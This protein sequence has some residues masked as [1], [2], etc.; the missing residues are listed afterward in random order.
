ME[1]A[2]FAAR[3]IQN[4][5][6]MFSQ[7]ICVPSICDIC[8]EDMPERLRQILTSNPSYEDFRDNLMFDFECNEDVIL[9]LRLFVT[10]MKLRLNMCVNGLLYRVPNEFGDLVYIWE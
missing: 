8:E 7:T 9:F 1:H 5:R 2:R 4:N 6:R 10:P 3:W